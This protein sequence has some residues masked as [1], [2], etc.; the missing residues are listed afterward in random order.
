MHRGRGHTVAMTHAS[1]VESRDATPAD[2]PAVLALNEESVHFLSP[3][4][5][6]RLE[7]LHAEAALHR[8]LTIDGQVAAFVLAFRE[9]ADYD[10][11]NYRWF[12]ERYERFLYIDRV[13]VAT[14]RQGRRLGALLYADL[15]DF[16]R[17]SGAARVTCEFDVDPPNEVS[18]RFHVRHGFVEVG[19]QSVAGGRKTVS[20]Q[21]VELG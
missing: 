20:L 5:G 12:A 2:F 11:V 16:A 6:E 9:G 8:V 19:A 21:A 14:A 4:T 3:M 7:R 13:V 1:S 15:F 10:S 17:A 18:R